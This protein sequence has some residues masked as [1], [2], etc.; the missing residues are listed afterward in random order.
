ML[1]GEMTREVAYSR[2]PEIAAAAREE[3]WMVELGAENVAEIRARVRG[4]VENADRW[5]LIGGP[6]CQAYSLAGRSRNSGNG[7]YRPEKDI[8]QKLYVEYLQILADHEPPVFVMENVKGLLSASLDGKRLF[9]RIRDDLGDPAKALIREGRSSNGTKP[10]Y[11][12]YSFVDHEGMAASDPRAFVIH[13]EAHGIPQ[14]RHRV[15]LLGLRRDHVVA[16]GLPRLRFWRTAPSV[17][18]AIGDLP[19]L[20]SG[21]SS[22]KKG[23]DAKDSVEA[24]LAHLKAARTAA[25]SGTIDDMTRDAMRHAL[26]HLAAP[27]M[28]RGAESLT[29]RGGAAVWN[30]STRGHML[31]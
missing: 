23:R 27:Q 12:L 3:A 30:H 5:V 31:Q 7:E 15:I 16:A 18:D 8:R 17:A 10:K 29:D 20:R 28:G 21:I 25:W 22:R 9:D 26:D 6:P 4:K 14:A 11:D 24:W 19:R 1:R 13:A 2:H